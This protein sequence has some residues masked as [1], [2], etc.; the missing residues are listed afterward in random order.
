LFC[1]WF[2]LSIM[3]LL[4]YKSVVHCRL[5]KRWMWSHLFSGVVSDEVVELLVAYTF[6]KSAP[7]GPP[8]SRVTGFLRYTLPLPILQ[9]FTEANMCLGYWYPALVCML[10]LPHCSS[11]EQYLE[12]VALVESGWSQEPPFP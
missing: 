12:S 1:D 11:I 7:N 9:Y 6:V 8:S 5:A 10:L 4:M 2:L 3:L